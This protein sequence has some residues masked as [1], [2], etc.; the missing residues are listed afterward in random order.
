MHQR[1]R[2]SVAVALAVVLAA[3]T[4]V[5]EDQTAEASPSQSVA[6]GGTRAE[7]TSSPEATESGPTALDVDWSVPFSIT[8]PAGWSTE[9]PE[10]I[11]TTSG[12]TAW[13]GAGPDRYLALSRSGE[14]TVDA[15]VE[16]VTTAEQLEATEPVETEIG[17]ASGYRVDLRT[18]DA[19]GDATCFNPGRCYTL[20]TDESGYW[21]VIEGRP[22]RAWF[23][24]VD[25]ETIVIATDAPERAFEEWAATVEGVLGTLTWTD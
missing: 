15:W 5:V 21:P 2:T 1:W 8:A 3:C 6:A 25:G 18:S 24:D 17:G 7:A 11:G 20:F 14:E 10:N 12:N 4:G 16:R 23:L 22:T 19:A 9:A 13:L